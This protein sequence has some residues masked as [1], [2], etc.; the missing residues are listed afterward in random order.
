M[1]K[2]GV[3]YLVPFFSLLTIMYNL[4][5][6][7]FSPCSRHLPILAC[8]TEPLSHWNADLAPQIAQFFHHPRLVAL[9]EWV[10]TQSNP[11][12]SKLNEWKWESK[13][14]LLDVR[15]EE[16][17]LRGEERGRQRAPNPLWS[18]NWQLLATLQKSR[19]TLTRAPWWVYVCLSLERKRL[20]GGTNQKSRVIA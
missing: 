8:V 5:C 18:S 15:R 13:C 1:L 12:R 14:S 4:V 9:S 3:Q 20:T 19:I 10:V 17:L 11:P 16:T 2:T 7:D 6:L